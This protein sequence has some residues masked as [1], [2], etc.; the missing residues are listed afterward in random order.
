MADN[1]L[2]GQNY[3]TPDIVAKVTGKA[4]YAED[5]RVEGML[6][7]KLLVSP[8]PHARIKRID[9][10]AAMAMPGVKA[11]LTS[12]RHA[13]RGGRCDPRRG[14]A[15]I[16]AGRTRAD[17]RAALPGRADSRDCGRRRTDRGARHRSHRHRIRAATLRR[18]SDR[19]AASRQ[20]ERAHAGQRLDASRG[21]AC[22]ARCAWAGQ[23]RGRRERRDRRGRWFG[24][25][26]NDSCRRGA[27]SG[28]RCGRSACG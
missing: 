28:C 19:I 25:R 21:A 15:G 9:T 22:G 23:R 11:I 16:G 13:R 7:A 3:T 18:R 10:T 2:I 27:P 26:H 5:Y 14:C 12:G 1:K 4:K 20:S 8:M 17:R 6:F 24:A